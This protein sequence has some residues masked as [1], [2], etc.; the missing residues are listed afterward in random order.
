MRGGSVKRCGESG[1]ALVL[2]ALLMVVL[3]GFTALAVDAAALAGAQVLPDQGQAAAEQVAREYAEK[4]GVDPDTLEFSFRCTSG[5]QLACD[6][7]AGK[8]DPIQVSGRLDVPFF[9]APAPCLAG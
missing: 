2:G 6:P 3:L 4:N 5:Y 9:F 7:G 1:Q 8:W